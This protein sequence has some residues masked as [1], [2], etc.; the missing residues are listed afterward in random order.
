MIMGVSLRLITPLNAVLAIF[1]LA[2]PAFA[3]PSWIPPAKIVNPRT[4]SASAPVSTLNVSGNWT[5]ND[6]MTDGGGPGCG[7]NSPVCGRLL[8][9]VAVLN[10]DQAGNITGTI[11][12]LCSTLD[13]LHWPVT[14]A[15]TGTNTFTLTAV[16]P[17][18]RIYDYWAC[19]G[20][21]QISATMTAADTASATWN[22]YSTLDPSTSGTM[23]K[24]PPD[25]ILIDPV[26]SDLLDGNAITKNV[27]AIA[28]APAP[29]YALG[30]AA[31]GAAQ[32]LL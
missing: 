14:G 18:S 26:A 21:W 15:I 25:V 12:T 2:S 24:S 32:V 1:I 31:D 27:D 29:V 22:P 13:G 7:S 10:Q 8:P 5:I 3:Q 23:A 20:S 30:V 9:Y 4:S 16:D 6:Y 11:T 28:G 17:T 19:A